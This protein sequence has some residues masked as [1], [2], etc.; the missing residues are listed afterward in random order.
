MYLPLIN[1]ET[2]SIKIKYSN[3]YKLP[4]K[5]NLLMYTWSACEFQV[6]QFPKSKQTVL[7]T[8][9]ASKYKGNLPRPSR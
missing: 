7:N 2:T 5:Y 6:I 4:F 3:L 8:Q 1:P 9:G